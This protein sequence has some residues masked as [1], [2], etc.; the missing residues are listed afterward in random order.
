MT[1]LTLFT[2][3][4][5]AILN[6]STL[7]IVKANQELEL[8]KKILYVFNS[9]DENMTNDEVNKLFE[10]K[11]TEED[12]KEDMPIY[13]FKSDEGSLKAIPFE[14]PGLWG[15]ITGYIGVD[16]SL[17]NVKGVEFISQNETPGLGGRISENPYKEQYRNIDIS[18]R[19]NNFIMNN[20]SPDGNIDAIAGATQTSNFVTQMI[21][22]AL[23]EYKGGGNK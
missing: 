11:I 17:N 22:K 9:Y 10:E 12:Y 13:T 4:I 21:N 20:P 8:R 19:D 16:E 18:G 3:L 1:A 7:D 6:Q 2:T 23:S 5:L 15:L 14:G